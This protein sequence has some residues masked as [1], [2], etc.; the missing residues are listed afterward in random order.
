MAAGAIF[1]SLPHLFRSLRR[2]HLRTSIVGF[3]E[4]LNGR[5]YEPVAADVPVKSKTVAKKVTRK[6]RLAVKLVGLVSA[7]RSLA[8]LS[9]PLMGLDLGQSTFVFFSILSNFG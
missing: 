6:D 2:G 4:D 1:F 5:S 9:V 8:L 7:V 3:S